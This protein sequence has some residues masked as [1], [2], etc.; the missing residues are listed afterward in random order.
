MDLALLST[1]F[2][3]RSNID[4]FLLQYRLAPNV[5]VEA[6]T[7]SALIEIVKNT[8]FVT[9]LPEPFCAA[10]PGLN[11]L[12]GAAVGRKQPRTIL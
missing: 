5:I 7:I 1:D 8:S 10:I 6:N 4:Q 11:K 12:M 3:T 2:V 9:I